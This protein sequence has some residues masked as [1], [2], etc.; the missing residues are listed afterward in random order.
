MKLSRE[1]K[2]EEQARERERALLAMGY[3]A[4]VNWSRD[5]TWALYWFEQIN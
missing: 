5:G 1:F 2:D 4:W 3:R